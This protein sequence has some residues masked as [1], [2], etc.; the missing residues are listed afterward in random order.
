MAPSFTFIH[1]Y[2][3]I[4]KKAHTGLQRSIQEFIENETRIYKKANVGL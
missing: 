4:Y 3:F 1:L 2:I